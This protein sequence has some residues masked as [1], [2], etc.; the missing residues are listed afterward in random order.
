GRTRRNAR[1]A[2]A[3]HRL[4]VSPGLINGRRDGIGM[5]LC[6]R[7]S[8]P[9]RTRSHRPERPIQ[10]LHCFRQQGLAGINLPILERGWASARGAS[11]MPEHVYRPRVRV[12]LRFSAPRA[13]AC[14]FKR[15]PSAD[16]ELGERKTL[17]E[18]AELQLLLG[19]ARY[20]DSGT[21]GNRADERMTLDLRKD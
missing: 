19:R 1:S 8:L 11:S 16:M 18:V 14:A 3:K 21:M 10:P 20:D 12:V 7:Y 5:Q 13:R 2:N 6:A 15:R 4:H 17:R 9:R